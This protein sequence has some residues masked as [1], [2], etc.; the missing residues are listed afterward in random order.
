MTRVLY[1]APVFA[2]ALGLSLLTGCA[3][4]RENVEDMVGDGS[5]EPRTLAFECDGGRDFTVRLSGDRDRAR[6]D[7]GSKTYELEYTGRDDDSRVY[8][9]DDDDEVRLTVGDDEAH[10][11]IPDESDYKDC[12]RT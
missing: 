5:D 3:D 8:S 2:G 6:V 4:L 1:P 11:R 10:L 7:V 9:D 12:E